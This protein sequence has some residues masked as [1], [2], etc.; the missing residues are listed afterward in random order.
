[1]TTGQP[2]T[3]L[4]PTEFTLLLV[5]DDPTVSH[6]CVTLLERRG[7]RVRAFFDGESALAAFSDDPGFCHLAILDLLDAQNSQLV[8]ELVA[9]SA[10]YDYLLDLMA[11][12]RAGGQFD[13]FL[14]PAE[15]QDLLARLR[16]YFG[17]A[18]YVPRGIE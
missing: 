15:Y 14:A 7:F 18:G 1:M 11:V 16:T 3:R 2:E 4:D 17:Q 8:A 5:D 6:L 12:Q 10:V 13:F 9:A